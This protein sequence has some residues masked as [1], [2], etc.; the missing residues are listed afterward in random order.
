MLNVTCIGDVLLGFSLA[1]WPIYTLQIALDVAMVPAIVFVCVLIYVIL[2]P[3]GT[4]KAVP[5]GL[6]LI[7]GQNDCVN[8]YE[9]VP[10]MVALTVFVCMLT[11]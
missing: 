6:T 4:Y 7:T 5:L 8:G 1:T 2:F 11:A 3:D 9:A 10:T